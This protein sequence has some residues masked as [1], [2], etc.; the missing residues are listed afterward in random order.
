MTEATAGATTTTTA[1]RRRTRSKSEPKTIV[2]HHGAM[3]PLVPTMP[4]RP[5][6]QSKS[7]CR[8]KMKTAATTTG[9]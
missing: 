4:R 5:E 8:R 1:K 9:L 7:S 3:C 2:T 6:E